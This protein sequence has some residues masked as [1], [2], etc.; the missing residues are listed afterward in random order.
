[1]ILTYCL[2]S[3]IF[4]KPLCLTESVFYFFGFVFFQNLS[5]KKASIRDCVHLGLQEMHS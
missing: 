5:F 3:R 1:M 4:R 2:I